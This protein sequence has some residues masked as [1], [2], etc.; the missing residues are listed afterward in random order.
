MTK[1]RD[2]IGGILNVLRNIESSVGDGWMN[3]HTGTP[4]HFKGSRGLNRDA[5]DFEPNSHYSV[6]KAIGMAALKP[7]DTAIV[8]GCGKGRILCHLAR[9]QI[10][11][12]IGIE[13]D[14]A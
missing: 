4:K 7:S 3:V 11:K 5:Y 1:I 6:M 8:L 10:K 2:A 14:P 13:L 9:K 12:A